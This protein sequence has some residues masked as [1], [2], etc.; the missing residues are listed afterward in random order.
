MVMLTVKRAHHVETVLDNAPTPD[1]DARNAA[2]PPGGRPL[3]ARGGRSPRCLRLGQ[4]PARSRGRAAARRRRVST[5]KSTRCRSRPRCRRR[6][7]SRTRPPSWPFCSA[8]STGRSDGAG[9]KGRSARPCATPAHSST[10]CPT[11][12]PGGA[13]LLLA[14]HHAMAHRGPRIGNSKGIFAPPRRPRRTPGAGV[15]PRAPPQPAG[16]ACSPATRGGARSGQ[17]PLLAGDRFQRGFYTHCTGDST[18]FKG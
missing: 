12:P 6:S 7:S 11:G 15:P 4:I 1:H 17:V 18:R 2:P 8:A 3:L 5:R 9:T 13:D 14:E 10:A 16:V